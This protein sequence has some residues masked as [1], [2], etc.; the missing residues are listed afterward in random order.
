MRTALVVGAGVAGPVAAMA[1]Q[2]AGIHAVVHEAHPAGADEVGSWLTLQANGIDALRAIDAHHLVAEVGFPTATM[3]FVNGKG[4]LLGTMSNGRSLADGTGSQMVRRADLYRGLRDVAVARGA[5]I[6]YGK[7]LIDATSEGGRVLARFADGTEA[8]GDL[9][10]GCD[11]IRSRTRQVIDPSAAPARYVP[12]LN[13][14]GYIPGFSVGTPTD[15]FQMMFG[16]RCFFGYSSTPDGGVVWFANP[17]LAEEPA[18]GEL[19]AMGDD[20]WRAWL[21]ELFADDAGPARDIVAAA[22]PL[23]G[24]ATYDMPKVRRWH[25]A[26]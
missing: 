17:P 22:P 20:Q 6:E 9:L 24:W 8:E 7:R 10:V 13:V 11:G 21:L 12:V 23:S 1:M 25:R 26:T 3:R 15:E 5:T 4:R 19:A 16:K 14:G 2:K 18:E